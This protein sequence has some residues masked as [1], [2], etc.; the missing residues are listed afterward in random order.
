[1]TFHASAWICSEGVGADD[2]MLWVLS[3]QG[4]PQGS[5]ISAGG[6]V[7]SPGVYAAF[8]CR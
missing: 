2:P 4:D 8:G 5:W 7:A 3:L 1:M 6:D